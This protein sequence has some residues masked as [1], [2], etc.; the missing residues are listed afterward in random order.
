MYPRALKSASRS[1]MPLGKNNLA[2][3][4]TW[5]LRAKGFDV[6]EWGT[7]SVKQKKTLVKD[8]SGDSKSAQLSPKP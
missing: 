2:E 4:V 8:M 7:Y 3:K 6:V 1:G 5:A